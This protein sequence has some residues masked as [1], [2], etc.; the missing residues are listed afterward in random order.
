MRQKWAVAGTANW[1]NS[2]AWQDGDIADADH[3]F[4]CELAQSIAQAIRQDPAGAVAFAR[5]A[6]VI[7]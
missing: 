1:S 5:N 2:N 4:A 7:L 3:Q 6:G